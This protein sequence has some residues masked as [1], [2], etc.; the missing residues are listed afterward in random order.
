MG[1]KTVPNPGWVKANKNSPAQQ[2]RTCRVTP[3]F[4]AKAA[5]EYR[6]RL[7]GRTFVKSQ[8]TKETT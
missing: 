1:T 7:Q 8:H 4:F 5:I 2:K 6:F 3:V